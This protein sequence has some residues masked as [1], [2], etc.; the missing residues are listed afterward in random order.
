MT[1]E[2]DV[3]GRLLDAHVEFARRQLTDSGEFEALVR[4]EI[5]YALR[6]AADLTL[7]EA[8]S[9]DLVKAVARKY[10]IAFPVEGAIPELVGRVAAR[11][12]ERSAA[13]DVA[14]A[15]LIG[16]KQ[17][18]DLTDDI[19]ALGL[20]RRLLERILDAPAT[21]DTLVEAVQR[22]VDSSRL[23][24]GLQRLVDGTVETV[25]RKGASY[26]LNANRADADD[27]LADT[28]RDLSRAGANQSIGDMSELVEPGDVE[29]VV[30]LV[31]EFWR[32]FRETEYFDGLLGDGVDE[33]FDTY[34]DTP[35]DELLADL[36][37]GYDDLV[38]EGLRFGPPVIAEIDDRG[39]LEAV[40]RRRL[41]P[42]YASG[43]FAA[44]VTALQDL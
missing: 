23:P 38:E 15:D 28:M 41:A 34:G 20:S 5:T 12:Y 35:L 17:I 9:R 33:V 42:F 13:D 30:V 39:F 22:S 29:D 24:A 32:L 43:E 27:L 36:G 3:A 25:T 18:D 1:A 2:N 21:V 14:L 44:A 8:V 37:I 6:D 26:V 31:F 19:A 11:L 10:A 4:E 7:S 16:R 40:L